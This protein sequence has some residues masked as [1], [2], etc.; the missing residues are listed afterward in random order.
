MNDEQ[1]IAAFENCTLAAAEFHH[2]QHVRIVWL[3]LRRHTLVETLVKFSEGLKRFA[4][5]NGKPNLYHET[6]TWAYVFLINERIQRG[7]SGQSWIEFKESNPDLLV[8]KENVLATYYYPETLF[9]D[10]AR[11][12]FLFPDKFAR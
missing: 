4:L 11:T 2:E 1:F 3:Y 10:R 8:W 7:E 9:S 5:R 12:I 6:I